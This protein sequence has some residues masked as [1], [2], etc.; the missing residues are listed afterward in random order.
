MVDMVEALVSD[1]IAQMNVFGGSFLYWYFPLSI[2]F[3]DWNCTVI[4]LC[5]NLRR[6][7]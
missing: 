5:L 7:L 1:A 3:Y 6:L 2:I 4:C